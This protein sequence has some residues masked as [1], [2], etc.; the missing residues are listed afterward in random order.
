M[1]MSAAEG[2]GAVLGAIDDMYN[3]GRAIG[4][5]DPCNPVNI[6]ETLTELVVELIVDFIDGIIKLAGIAGKNSL[7]LILAI[8][9][10]TYGPSI[11]LGITGTVGFLTGNLIGTI[12]QSLAMILA[13]VDGIKMILMYLAAGATMSALQQRQGFITM[14]MMQTIDHIIHILQLLDQL[15]YSFDDPYQED[16][17]DIRAAYR[18]VRDASLILGKEADKAIAEGNA[19]LDVGAIETVRE[20]LHQAIDLL[21]GGKYTEMLN[22][23]NEALGGIDISQ[24]LNLQIGATNNDWSGGGSSWN[25]G[26]YSANWTQPSN[27]QAGNIEIS[28]LSDYYSLLDQLGKA[29][30]NVDHSDQPLEG[31]VS[32][33]FDTGAWTNEFTGQGSTAITAL[34][35]DM[36]HQLNPAFQAISYIQ[37]VKVDLAQL[38]EKTP[39]R[40]SQFQKFFGILEGVAKENANEPLSE[41]NFT[42]ASGGDIMKNLIGDLA[43][44]DLLTLQSV[45]NKCRLTEASITMLNFNLGAISATGGLIESMIRPIFALLKGVRTDMQEFLN[46]TGFDQRIGAAALAGMGSDGFGSQVWDVGTQ[47]INW[48]TRL[49]LVKSSLTAFTTTLSLPGGEPT[50]WM[51]TDIAEQVETKWDQL[52][53]YLE[54]EGLDIWMSPDKYPESQPA[55]VAFEMM[56]QIPSSVFLELG[57]GNRG[58]ITSRG[59]TDYSS[60]FASQVMPSIDQLA[61]GEPARGLLLAYMQELKSQFSLQFGID[62]YVYNECKQIRYLIEQHPGF[63][64]MMAWWNGLANSMA[65]GPLAALGPDLMEGNLDT[66]AS[67][68]SNTAAIL[69][70]PLYRNLGA[71][72]KGGIVPPEIIAGGIGL[73]PLQVPDLSAQLNADKAALEIG[74]FQ[75]DI[76]QDIAGVTDNKKWQE[77]Q[78]KKVEL[79]TNMQNQSAQL[80]DIITQLGVIYAIV[81]G[82]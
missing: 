54:N 19:Y 11:L 78:K 14:Y 55:E 24:G 60:T 22:E 77:F 29:L 20:L 6:I 44:E 18:K 51:D 38:S 65:D 68:V 35:D 23:V 16:Y 79:M 27:N 31:S 50:N 15:Q 32:F 62:Q 39:L 12:M 57:W 5:E 67:A 21:L 10:E 36:I 17:A 3:I 64:S 25:I 73:D 28:S 7:F 40:N 56:Q 49:E 43:N 75:E 69:E 13:Q 82:A 37:L 63:N 76:L 30:Y 53:A 26:N 59:E 47:K 1:A 61:A 41:G 80:Q 66:L 34:I 4:A 74:K 71:C 52:V 70:N 81:G 45:N 48:S 42:T 8:L 9:Q 58:G 46:Q 2:A 33:D 72:V